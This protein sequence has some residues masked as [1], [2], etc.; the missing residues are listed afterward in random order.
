[1]ERLPYFIMAGALIVSLAAALIGGGNYWFVPAAIW[2][3]ILVYFVFDRRL[4]Q[5]ESGG[6]RAAAE[7]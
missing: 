1:V 7:G 3:V 6:E 4:K 5:R 2:P